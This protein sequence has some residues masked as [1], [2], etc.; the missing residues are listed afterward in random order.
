MSGARALKNRNKH[1]WREPIT[2]PT[3][4]SCGFQFNPKKTTG[5][6]KKWAAHIGLSAFN[7]RNWFGGSKKRVEA[8]NFRWSRNFYS[9]FL[10]RNW[11]TMLN[12]GT[13]IRLSEISLTYNG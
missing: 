9:N 7:D 8:R 6:R 3:G 4:W 1:T 10:T 11:S 13:G 5:E 12:V 2:C